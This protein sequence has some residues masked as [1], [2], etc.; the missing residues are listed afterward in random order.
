MVATRELYRSAEGERWL[1]VRGSSP[2][3][4]W[5]RYLPNPRAEAADFEVGEFLIRGIFAPEHQALLRLIG[6]LVAPAND[7]VEP[8]NDGSLDR[9]A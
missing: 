9:V 6:T 4:V 5:I 2:E 3:R 8:A 1:L 7:L